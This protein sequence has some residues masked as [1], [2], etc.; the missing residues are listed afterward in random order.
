MRAGT[1]RSVARIALALSFA[2]CATNPVTQEREL[3]FVSLEEPGS[4]TEPDPGS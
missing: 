4:S 2:A 1:R 3:S